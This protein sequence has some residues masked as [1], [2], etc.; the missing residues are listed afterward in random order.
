VK[1]RTGRG[2]LL[3]VQG[4]G[5]LTG[6]VFAS[7]LVWL[8]YQRKVFRA[9]TARALAPSLSRI[10]SPNMPAQSGHGQMEAPTAFYTHPCPSHALPRYADAELA[11]ASR[12]RGKRHSC[13]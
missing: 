13:A 6:L 9:R 12:I 5:H 4:V 8:A 7:G 3:T 11:L 2:A 10:A 1:L